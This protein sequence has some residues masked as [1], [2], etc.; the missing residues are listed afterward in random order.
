MWWRQHGG[1]PWGMQSPK[2]S[3]L[4]TRSMLLSIGKSTKIFKIFDVLGFAKANIEERCVAKL[5]A[6]GFPN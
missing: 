4:M 1:L 5:L 2:N 6:T 3:G